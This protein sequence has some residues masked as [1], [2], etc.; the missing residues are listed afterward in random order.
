VEGDGYFFSL[1]DE[2]NNNL[3]LDDISLLPEGNPI[4]NEQESPIVQSTPLSRSNQKRTKKFS[5]QEDALLVSAWELF[6]IM[7]LPSAGFAPLVLR[8]AS[9]LLWSSRARQLAGK[10][11][12]SF[13]RPL[14]AHA[15]GKRRRCPP[16]SSTHRPLL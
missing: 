4:S 3:S 14:T 2:A 16:H 7:I 8:S 11:R 10:V 12:F 9:S 5:E 13:E 1:L 15:L 6:G